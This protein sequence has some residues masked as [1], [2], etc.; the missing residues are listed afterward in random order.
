VLYSEVSD[1]AFDEVG[2]RQRQLPMVCAAPSWLNYHL[3]SAGFSLL[4]FAY[5]LSCP[6]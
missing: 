2:H 3:L 4:C 1:V 5:T 6:R